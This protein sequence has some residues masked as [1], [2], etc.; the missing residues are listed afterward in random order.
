MARPRT[1]RSPEQTDAIGAANIDHQALA[2]AGAAATQ[3]AQQLAAIDMQFALDADQYTF[4]RVRMLTPAAIG[5]V[6]TGMLWLGRALI[7]VEAHETRETYRAYLD[8]FEI[9]DRTARQYKHAARRFNERPKLVAL[10][11]SKILALA[12]ESDDT[13]DELE[14]NDARLDE[15]DCMTVRELKASLRAER[16]EHADE[17]AAD[18]EIIRNK[19]E[20]INKLMRSKRKLE[21]SSVR[22][23]IDDLLRDMDEAAVLL[24]QQATLLVNGIT[25]I[26]RAYDEAGE[27]AEPEVEARISQNVDLGAQWLRE[28]AAKD[29]E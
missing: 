4:D 2:E 16:K 17:K 12:S 28:L 26:R 10:G 5:M 14:D 7:L 9:A 11:A 19:D 27:K 15:L 8:E 22:T 23:Q 13:L 1:A 25:D 20:R 21:T 6:S 18:E 29:G 24:A 3:H